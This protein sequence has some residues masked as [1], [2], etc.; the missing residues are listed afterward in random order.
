MTHSGF[1][2]LPLL[3]KRTLLQNSVAEQKKTSQFRKRKELLFIT[4]N[5]KMCLKYCRFFST[6]NSMRVVFETDESKTYKGF[7]AEYKEGKIPSHKIVY[8]IRRQ[9]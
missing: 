9:L 4:V 5:Y 1:M 6:S 3:T 2:M 8:N 7:L